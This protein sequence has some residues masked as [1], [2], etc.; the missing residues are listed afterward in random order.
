MFLLLHCWIWLNQLW[1]RLPVAIWFQTK[2]VLCITQ[3][4][5]NRA[6]KWIWNKWLPIIFF[7]FF[8]IQS[9]WDFIEPFS[10]KTPFLYYTHFQWISSAY[11]RNCLYTFFDISLEISFFRQKKKKTTKSHSE[12]GKLI[13]FFHL[14]LTR[15]FVWYPHC[16]ISIVG[17][18]Y[19]CMTKSVYIFILVVVSHRKISVIKR[20][21]VFHVILY[22]EFTPCGLSFYNNNIWMNDWING[23]EK[24]ARN[25]SS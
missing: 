3:S 13:R 20:S 7:I 9:N 19:V 11:Q 6:R 1:N 23:I 17:G 12:K 14:Q 25:Q 2:I 16:L 5:E 4:I 8:S 18:H 22:M 15:I 24:N 10:Y 21:A